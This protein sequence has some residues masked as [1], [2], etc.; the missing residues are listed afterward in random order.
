MTRV[1][2]LPLALVSIRAMPN[3][4]TGLSSHEIILGRPFP[5]GMKEGAVPADLTNL[6]EIQQ[7]YV[8]NLFTFV[9]KYLQQ[10]S[11][12][13]PVLS[14]KPTHPFKPGDLVL[15]RSLKPTATEPRYSP[16][17]VTRTA[18]KVKGLRGL[19]P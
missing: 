7:Q 11:E 14:N 19:S 13:T 12:V 1:D 18:L 2:A 5:R 8:H 9:S 17:V 16:P 10:V 3:T 15:V 4:L 6:H